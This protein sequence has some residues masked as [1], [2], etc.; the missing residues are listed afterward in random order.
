MEKIKVLDLYCGYGGLSMG[1]EFTKAFEVVGGIDF[2]DWAVKTFYYNHPQLNK[3]KV[4][5]KP[6][7]MTNLE[8]S[9]VLKDIGGKPDIIVGGPPCQGFSFAGKRL[10]EYMHDKRNEQ[11]FHFLRFIKEIKPKAFLM[12]N[13]AG[14]RVTGQQKKG[15]LIDYLIEEYEKMGYATSWQVVN[16]ADYRVP[17]NRKRFMLVGVLKGK[18]FIFPEAPIQDNNLFGGE[19]RLTV[20]DALSDLP[21]PNHEEP[22]LHTIQ[23]LT[24]LQKFLRNET[25]TIANH[26]VTVHGEEMIE[27]LKK[28]ENGTRLY[29]NWNHSWYKLDPKRPSPAVKENHRAPFVHFR[30]PRA[31][32]PRECARLQTVPDSYV[33]LGTKTAQLIMIGNAVPA[34]LSAHV[35]TE[36]A[37]QIFKVE[38]KTPWDKQ[39]NPL[40]KNWLP[41]ATKENLVSNCA[42]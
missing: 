26:L 31:T 21:S 15:Q 11:V 30:E 35:A 28:Q 18:K 19:E 6:C 42:I 32:S 1:F 8:T 9:E 10:D 17:Q 27:R 2:Y 36:I 13:V 38:P 29:P 33:F 3:L 16:S 24:P 39:N 23:P 25:D 14:I 34:I 20:Y 41:E 37:R 4:I 22:Q 5:N 7:D 40:T 12:E